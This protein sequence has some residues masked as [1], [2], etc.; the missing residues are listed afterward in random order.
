MPLNK[1][2]L[3]KIDLLLQKQ[4]QPMHDLV[5]KHEQSLYGEHGNNGLKGDV[6]CLYEGMTK[7]REGKAKMQGAA[8]ALGAI[9]G[10][11]ATVAAKLFLG[12]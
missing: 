12:K 5:M 7:L 3:D 2:D 1:S 4:I 11:I 9:G 6:A 10:A 8:A